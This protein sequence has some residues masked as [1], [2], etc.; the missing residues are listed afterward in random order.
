MGGAKAGVPAAKAVAPVKG[1]PAPPPQVKAPPA[2]LAKAGAAPLA[3]ARLA[4]VPEE[5]PA[6]PVK[7]PLAGLVAAAAKV[8]RYKKVQRP[9]NK[10]TQK[11]RCRS[12]QRYKRRTNDVQKYTKTRKCCSKIQKQIY[13]KI[14]KH[15]AKHIKNT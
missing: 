2:A 10:K 14:L 6:P 13:G 11:I 15:I 7:E 1:P 5:A 3:K 8:K 9:Q 4:V 12:Q